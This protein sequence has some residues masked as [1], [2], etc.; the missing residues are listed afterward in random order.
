MLGLRVVS[1][2]IIVGVSTTSI[3]ALVT[4][5]TSFWF[6]HAGL[7]MLVWTNRLVH[8]ELELAMIMSISFTEDQKSNLRAKAAFKGL[9]SGN[10]PLT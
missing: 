1:P 6:R 10:I 2:D 7:R 4:T 3:T 8:R 5:T 9:S